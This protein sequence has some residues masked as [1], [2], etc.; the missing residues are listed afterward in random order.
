[1]IIDAHTHLYAPE[2]AADPRGWALLNGEPGWAECV[3]PAGRP[4][5]QA[6]SSLPRLLADM[7]Q[8]GIGKCVLL[9]WYWERQETCEMQN[10]WHLDWIRAHPDRLLAF[11]AVQPAAGRA[12]IEDLERA[13]DAGL[14]GVGEILPQAQGF[15][16]DDPWWLRVVEIAAG[17]GVP[18][19]LHVTDPQAPKAAGPPTPVENYLR[20]A[21]AFPR[22]RFILAHWGGGLAFRDPGPG[23]APLPTNLF[24]DT[25]ASPLLY[26]RNIFRRAL[27]RV[28]ADRILYG[29]DYPLRLYPRAEREPGFR[30][31]LDEIAESGLTPPELER[32]LGGNIRAL[33]PA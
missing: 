21:A 5:I 22:G 11:A 24:F 10:K 20:L 33:L 32:V 12:A 7:D 18:M 8:A 2:V 25:A 9:G 3:A 6:W 28:G 1:M 29:S 26:D 15:G 13:L 17:R 27:D 31:F 4:S 30:R 16:Y 19:T 23:D 14:C